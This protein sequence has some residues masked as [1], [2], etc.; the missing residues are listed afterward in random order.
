MNKNAYIEMRKENTGNVNMTGGKLVMNKNSGLLLNTNDDQGID[1]NAIKLIVNGDDA[2]ITANGSNQISGDIDF[3]KGTI[4]VANGA[5]LTSG[6]I[7]MKSENAKIDLLGKL[8]TKCQRFR[9]SLFQK[10]C[11]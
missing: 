11:R 9:Q 5:S 10:L 6:D 1:G 4:T 2:T 8:N 7:A 3:T